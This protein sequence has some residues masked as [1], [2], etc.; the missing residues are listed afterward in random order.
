MNRREEIS[1]TE[2][3]LDLIRD[4]SNSEKTPPWT[5]VDPKGR[6]RRFITPVNVGVEISDLDLRL[7]KLRQAASQKW[8]WLDSKRI[9]FPAG[10]SKTDTPFSAFLKTTLSRFC[11]GLHRV[12]I[13]C[14]LS[15]PAVDIR[16]LKIPKV[17]RNQIANAVFWT[18]KKEMNFQD[19][20]VVFNYQI[21]G[22]T[23]ENGVSKTEIMAYTAPRHETDRLKALFDAAGFDLAG[24]TPLSFALQNL[25]MKNA[26][27]RAQTNGECS[28]WIGTDWSCIDLFSEGKLVLSRGIRAGMNSMIEAI[29]DEM[30]PIKHTP[31][32]GGLEMENPAGFEGDSR[33]ADE[34]TGRAREMLFGVLYPGASAGG[35][36]GLC[37]NE[38]FKMVHPVLQRLV[39]QV[40]RTLKHYSM[41]F[42]NKVMGRIYLSGPLSGFSPMLD[43]IT[44]QLDIPTF[45]MNPW[46]SGRILA[47]PHPVFSGS[48][49][50]TLLAVAAGAALCVDPLSPNLLM[51]QKEQSQ[52]EQVRRI[53]RGV[54]ILFLFII[55]FLAGMAFWHDRQIGQKRALAAEFHKQ[56]AGCT[57]RVDKKLILDQV[58]RIKNAE[59]ALSS[60]GKKLLSVAIVS[61][62]ANLT[63]KDIRLLRIDS[64]PSPEPA[65][66]G[67]PP[68][69]T[70]TM[71]GVVFGNRQ[72]F[73]AILVGYFLRLKNSPIFGD[74]K[75]PG[76]R[77]QTL[78]DREVLRF[79][80]E[81]TIEDI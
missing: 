48:C 35:D 68:K 65:K 45:A 80:G 37:E 53:N 21:I 24:I 38:I 44:R 70:L 72:M 47:P 12:R 5:P 19:S 7:V 8:E 71:D 34:A 81:I 39:R 55:C 33:Q 74:F 23:S 76:R 20:T 50:Q 13:W 77:C 9:P 78:N 42:N 79:T 67:D 56:L 63:P 36:G 52:M 54:L 49:E 51:T 6:R 4:D 16:Y 18:Y 57:P 41:H 27:S 26:P 64:G 46:E 31:P 1:S 32:S 73:D 60:H 59:N 17:P 62:L 15:S 29:K 25:M 2:K 40:D 58:M 66:K 75:I 22:E 69:R 11:Q 3:L 10:L 43:Y 28:L 14:A 30:L 61:E